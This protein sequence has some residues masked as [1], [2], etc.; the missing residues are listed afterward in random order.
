[1]GG[2]DSYCAS[3]VAFTPDGGLIAD[4]SPIQIWDVAAGREIKR[5]EP[6]GSGF[7]MALSTDGKRLLLGEDFRG[8]LEMIE[9]W[10]VESGK[11]LGRFPQQPSRSG[12]WPARRTER[13]QRLRVA[14]VPRSRRTASSSCGA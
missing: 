4:G 11:L 5:F 8:Y 10:D 2:G 14:K 3:H 1:M 7:G 9:L 12:V 6:Q 13:S